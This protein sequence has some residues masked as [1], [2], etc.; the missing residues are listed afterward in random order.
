MSEVTAEDNTVSSQDPVKQKAP[1]TNFIPD[2]LDFYFT[3]KDPYDYTREDEL[4]KITQ[5]FGDYDESREPGNPDIRLFWNALNASLWLD[6]ETLM[7]IFWFTGNKEKDEARISLVQEKLCQ[8]IKLTGAPTTYSRFRISTSGY[9]FPGVSDTPE[10]SRQSVQKLMKKI[11]PVGSDSLYETS[12]EVTTKLTRGKRSTTYS[13]VR[14]QQTEIS[15]LRLEADF[16]VTGEVKTSETETHITSLDIR[17]DLD[18]ER[19][20]LVQLI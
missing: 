12:V 16:V 5:V 20:K 14:N 18:N 4:V 8:Y 2:S 13:A 1:M 19:Q 6:H 9:F 15:A 11:L 3:F 17:K 7:I 10:T